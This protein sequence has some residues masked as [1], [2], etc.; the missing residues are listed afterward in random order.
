M[1]L[2]TVVLAIVGLAVAGAVY[3]RLAP[4]DTAVWHVDPS[5]AQ[6]S[7]KPNDFLVAEGGDRPPVET[8]KPVDAVITSLV[9][10]I[11]ALPGVSELTTSPEAG[12]YTYVQRS[13]LM[14]YPDVLSFRVIPNGD[15]S[16]ITFWSRSRFGQSDLGVNRQRVDALLA[17][18]GLDS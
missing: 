8:S 5:E 12:L 6:R 18:T 10:D 2:R 9:T 16:R 13:R 7:G 17:R 3:V 4:M 14:G 15:G 11:E 1:I